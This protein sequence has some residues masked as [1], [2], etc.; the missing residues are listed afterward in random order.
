MLI[1]RIIYALALATA[2]SACS[3]QGMAVRQTSQML[4]RTQIIFDNEYDLVFAQEAMPAQIK[5]LEAMLILDPKN[6]LLLETLT[7]AYVGYAFL[8]LEHPADLNYMTSP[9]EAASLKRR[10]LDFYARGKSYALRWLATSQK[11]LAH[12]IETHAE[13]TQKDTDVLDSD[14]AH[15]AFWV[16]QAIASALHI[17]QA[18]P[19]AMRDLPN[20]TLLFENCLKTDESYEH[21]GA[22]VALGALEASTPLALG[23]NPDSV[24]AHF[25]KA[26]LLTG[27]HDALVHVLYVQYAAMQTHNTSFAKSTLN[28]ILAR[29]LAGMYPRTLRNTLA[30]EKAPFLL[31]HTETWVG[32]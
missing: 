28:D 29:N 6:T 17:T 10:A 27:N 21:A 25:E 8:F 3:F 19:L 22:H 4:A 2:L 5:N 11:S 15:A 12:K 14:S 1:P 18:W 31:S 7:K 30:L 13:L 9:D 23:G 32:E 26:L 24:R 20:I 16:A